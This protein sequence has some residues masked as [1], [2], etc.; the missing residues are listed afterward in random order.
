MASLLVSLPGGERSR[1][2]RRFTGGVTGGIAT[3]V[4]DAVADCA[5]VCDL[6]AQCNEASNY[7]SAL[8]I[9]DESERY[10][11]D[12]CSSRTIERGKQLRDEH[13]DALTKAVLAGEG[14][15][16]CVDLIDGCTAEGARVHVGEIDEM[17]RPMQ[18]GVPLD[19]LEG[20]TP[21]R[22]KEEL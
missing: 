9:A 22:G 7:A 16:V 3:T 2:S 21:L 15:E 20:E 14:V 6:G 19:G 11:W 17:M 13:A 12:S 10:S 1:G 8:R 4:A 5:R 18:E